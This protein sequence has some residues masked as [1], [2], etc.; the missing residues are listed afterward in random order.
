MILWQMNWGTNALPIYTKNKT[1]D[2]ANSQN[3]TSGYFD[4]YHGS[5]RKLCYQ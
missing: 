1:Y 4:A 2:H 5:C 3:I